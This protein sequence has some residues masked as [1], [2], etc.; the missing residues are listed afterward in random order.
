[1]TRGLT[2]DELLVSIAVLIV[3][4]AILLVWA[5]RGRSRWH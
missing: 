5:I 2:L 4:G 3:V 1:M